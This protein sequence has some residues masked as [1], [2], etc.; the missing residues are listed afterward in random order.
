VED[1]PFEGIRVVEL[2]QWVFVPTAGMLLADWGAD[3]IRVER[4]TG[5]AYGGLATQGIGRDSTGGVNLSLAL[6]NRGKRSMV[7]DLS[8][9]RGME[10]MHQLLERADVFV[11]N[12]RGDALARLGLDADT[13]T[14]RFPRLVYARGHG[15]GAQGP[16]AGRSGYDSSAFWA[17]GG[18]AHVLTPPEAGYPI[19]PRGAMGDRNAGMALGFGIAAALLRQARAGKGSVV[20]TSLLATAV[21][22][23]AS[24]VLTALQGGIPAQIPRRVN[25]VFGTYR[26]SDG[27]HIQLSMMESDRYWDVF[28]RAL[29]REDLIDDRRFVDLAA[30]GANKEACIAELEEEFAKRTFAECKEMLGAI[31]VPWAPVQA[32]EELLDDPQ[33]V[34]NGYLGE[35]VVECWPTYRLPTAPVQLDGRPTELRRAPEVGEHT[36]EILLELGYSWDD[37]V[38]L[39]D[40]GATL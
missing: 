26:T 16:D 39:S 4:A 31:D 30:R 33:V 5:D 23:L 22:T 32:V 7:L 29:G 34:A 28:C 1:A 8:S 36:E 14:A 9:E 3:V 17:R 2:A 12:L 24:D 25:P 11:T 18:L 19:V 15:Y 40:Q 38:A 35:V 10:I 20:D 6:V 37:I 13:L 27:R 21:W